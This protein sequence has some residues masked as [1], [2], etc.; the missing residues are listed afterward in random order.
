MLPQLDL[1]TF[2]SQ[3]FWLIICLGVIYYSL[4]NIYIPRL[5]KSI[6]ARKA[7]IN[8]MVEE[9][10][11]MKIESEKLNSQYQDEM[12]SVYKAT[13]KIRNLTLSIFE[14]KMKKDLAELAKS[15]EKKIE[16]FYLEKQKHINEVDKQIIL[17]ANDLTNLL[18]K[19]IERES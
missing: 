17:K 2:P 8:Y 5:E 13:Q 6:N 16:K 1:T 14:K 4:A 10:S 9:A 3:I 11:K 15:Q 18:I 19:K 7:H 12:K